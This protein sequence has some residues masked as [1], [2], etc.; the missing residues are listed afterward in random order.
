MLE[1]PRAALLALWGTAVLRGDVPAVAAARAVHGDDEPHAVT[2]GTAATTLDELLEELTASGTTGLRAVLPAP[3]DPA[4]LAGPAEFTGEATDAGEAVLAEGGRSALGLVPKVAAFGSAL[5]PGV[6]VT[7]HVQE[8]APARPASEG[9]A[10]AD[11]AL[12]EAL[13][14]AT[15]AL[16]GLDV[17]RWRDDAADRIAAVRDGGLRHGVLP[18]GT[19]ARVARVLTT[20]ARVRAIAALALE[21]DGAALTGWQAAERFRA[22]RDVDRVAR[23]ALAVAATPAPH[24]APQPTRAPRTVR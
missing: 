13:R 5:E 6:L 3:G 8:V 14:T 4:G 19:D 20:A 17:S 22:L 24:G 10:D 16:A 7:W 12:R 2:G 9:V 1:L 15:D 23:S 11:R 21:D 18:P